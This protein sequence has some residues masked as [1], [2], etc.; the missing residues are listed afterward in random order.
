[1]SAE[2]FCSAQRNI[3]FTASSRPHSRSRR[4]YCSAGFQCGF[5]KPRAGNVR[6]HHLYAV[7]SGSICISGPHDRT[8]DYSAAWPDLR[9][10]SV[11]I[12]PSSG[13]L[14]MQQESLQH[15]S[16]CANPYQL[17]GLQWSSGKTF[18]SSQACLP[19]CAATLHDNVRQNFFVADGAFSEAA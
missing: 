7:V 1:M 11:Y 8:R 9:R 19:Q 18:D 4:C 15:P 5:M 16:L 10:G 6:S 13:L 3:I 17:G 12:S 2:K 14:R